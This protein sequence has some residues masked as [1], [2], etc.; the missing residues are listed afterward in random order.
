[1]L[2][3]ACRYPGANSLEEYWDLMQDSGKTAVGVRPKDRDF[4]FPDSSRTTDLVAGWLSEGLFANFDYQAF[5][6]SKTEAQEMDV[7][8]RWALELTYEAFLDA[9]IVVENLRGSSTA[10]FVGSYIAGQ[11]AASFGEHGDGRITGHS[12]TGGNLGLIANRIAYVFDFHGE[13]F[14]VDNACASSLTAVHKACEALKVGTCELAVVVGTNALMNQASF[15]G[16]KKAGML[17]PTGVLSAFDSSADGFVRGEG[18]GCVILCSQRFLEKRVLKP[19]HFP[20]RTDTEG[21][22]ETVDLGPITSHDICVLPR[23]YCAIRGHGTNSN[24]KTLSLTRPSG[25]AQRLLMEQILEDFQLSRDD[26]VYVE[27]HGTGT[28]VGDCI[29]AES[30]GKVLQP[31]EKSGAF[32]IGSVKGFI[33]HQESGAGVAGLIRVALQ[34]QHGVLCPTA[35]FQNP[36]SELKDWNIRVLKKPETVLLKPGVSL[37]GVNSYGFGGGNAFTVVGK[38]HS[39]FDFRDQSVVAPKPLPFVLVLSAHSHG[40]MSRLEEHWETIGSHTDAS[41][42]LYSAL[43]P[44]RNRFRRVTIG[45]KVLRQGDNNFVKDVQHLRSVTFVFGGQG[46][47]SGNAGAVLFASFPKFRQTILQ[48]D[49][50]YA[51]LSGFSLLQRGFCAGSTAINRDDLFFVV[52]AVAFFQAALADLLK[53]SEDLSR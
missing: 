44:A 16:F 23:A 33:G 49:S 18:C 43:Q 36:I 42:A 27:A 52:P 2:G 1:V 19:R 28:A 50:M 29:E 53:Q 41:C 37:M 48:M 51:S 39:P 11:Q 46:I 40:Q 5:G 17:S 45:Q 8:Q 3:M 15:T 14:C 25:T 10:V 47:W 4:A 13:S 30:I 12:L 38:L 26:F 7:Q 9:S 20:L 24:G 21:L 32:P 6:I 35:N 31:D 34:I 22:D